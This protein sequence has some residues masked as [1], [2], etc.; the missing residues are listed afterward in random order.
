MQKPSGIIAFLT[1][2]GSLDPY[3][4]TMDG[5][6]LGICPSAKLVKITNS[7]PSFDIRRASIELLLTYRY[8][9]PGTVFVVVVVPGVGNSI[10]PILIVT[11]NYFFV[12]PDNGILIAAAEDDGIEDAIS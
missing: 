10:R 9:P 2:V 3:S 12:D 1:D 8:F 6:A 4:A 11:K 5:V 7:I